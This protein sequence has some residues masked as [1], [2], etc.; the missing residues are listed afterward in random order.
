[1]SRKLRKRVWL[2]PPYN[3]PLAGLL[4]AVQL[5]LAFMLGLHLERRHEDLTL[6]DLRA[7][8]W[9]TPTAFLLVLLMLLTLGAMVRFAH[10]ATG[11]TRLVLGLVHASLQ[12]SSVAGVMIAASR[13]TGALDLRGAPGLLAFLGLVLVLGGVGGTLGMSGYL[14]ATNCLGFHGNEAYAPLHH[15]DLK[16]FLRLHI[17]GDGALVVLPVGID[18]VGRRWE[19]RPDVPDDAPWFD[20]VGDEPEAHLIEAPVR[21]DC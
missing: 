14:W 2:L 10:G 11:L 7:A 4:G 3:M 9:E 1:V 20:P 21:I 19:I 17:D 18:R 15:Q 8:V 13:L 5:L 12:L 6:H 16:H